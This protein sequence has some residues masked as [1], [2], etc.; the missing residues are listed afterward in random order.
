MPIFVSALPRRVRSR[1]AAPPLRGLV[2]ISSVAFGWIVFLTA[3]MTLG[4][5]VHSD[6]GDLDYR[7][8]IYP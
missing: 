8:F 3:V 6:L 7:L 1:E 2:M 5:E 4:R